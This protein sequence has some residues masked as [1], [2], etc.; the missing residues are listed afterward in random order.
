MRISLAL[1]ALLFWVGGALA[2]TGTP[3]TTT[4]LEAEVNALFPDNT[5]G[6]ITPFNARQTLLDIISSG[7]SAMVSGNSCSG[8]QLSDYQFFA[9]T[10]SA[11]SVTLNIWDGTQ[12][13]QWATLNTST[14]GFSFGAS[15][16]GNCAVL[17]VP[18]QA[19]PQTSGIATCG[20][21]ADSSAGNIFQ[22]SGWAD[23]TGTRAVVGVFGQGRAMGMNSLSWGGNFVG[24]TNAAGAFAQGI[25]VDFGVLS[26]SSE[27]T[28]GIDINVG[29]V[30]NGSSNLVIGLSFDQLATPGTM[31]DAIRFSNFAGG[32]PYQNALINVPNSMVPITPTYGINLANANFGTAAILTKNFAVSP[33]GQLTSG[34]AGS[35]GA[36]TLNG[37]SSGSGALTVGASG[38]GFSMSSSLGITTNLAVGTT[39]AI[40]TNGGTAG[41]VQLNGSTSGDATITASATGGHLRRSSSSTPTLTSGCNGTGSSVVGTDIIGV[42]GNQTAAATTCTLQFG[43]AY[44]AAVPRCLAIGNTGPLTS[45]TSTMS[46]LVVTFASTANFIFTYF[47][48]GT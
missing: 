44:T 29:G 17:S 13:V 18:T 40:G 6:L 22:I 25:E 20:V 9:N 28:N 33:T 46:T 14:H 16:T 5:G 39:A 15:S 19:T 10:S 36:L 11:P 45:V 24:Y 31:T 27:E 38:G 4:A 21:Y 30:T 42:A 48:D 1:V 8:L 2:Q 34:A 3:K 47:C 26:G 12:C 41:A 43:T 32:Q 23:N 35:G 7:G 37:S